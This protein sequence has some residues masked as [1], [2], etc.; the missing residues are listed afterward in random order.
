MTLKQVV[1]KLT[2]FML[3]KATEMKECLKDCYLESLSG[4][5][6]FEIYLF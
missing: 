6:I 1:K 4:Q 2:Y 5:S 3:E